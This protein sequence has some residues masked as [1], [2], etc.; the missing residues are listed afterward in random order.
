MNRSSA[1][2]VAAVFSLS[3]C[4]PVKTSPTQPAHGQFTPSA[5]TETMRKVADWQIGSWSTNGFAKPKYNWTYCAAYT[6]IFQAGLATGDGKYH[7]FLRKVGADLQ[8]RTGKRRYFADDYC[9]GQVFSQ[10]YAQ[11]RQPEMIAPWRT[12]A[13]EIVGK[14]NNESL[15]LATHDIIEREWA[16]CDALFMGPT[17]LAYL[18]T[19]T[20]DRKY[21][22][23]ALKLWWKTSDF[24]YS[25]EERLYF[26]DESYFDK[27][28]K[29]GKKVFWSRGNGWVMA[30]MV[31]V[32][33]NMPPDHPDRARLL[34]QYRAMAARIAGLQTA[35]GTWH[36]SL[37]DPGSFPT[38]ETSGTA[39]YTYAILWGLNSGM[40][41]RAT[42]WPVV[43]RA[44]PALA[45]AVQPDGKLGYVQPVGAAPD[46]VDANS[47]ETYGPG[48]FLLAG[49]ELLEYIKR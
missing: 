14:P 20:G 13:D 2:L 7:D 47:T 34:A 9:V 35:D 23:T 6:G 48:A 31:R 17:S 46:K 21:L 3:A 28:E 10:L 29:N 12:L 19:V 33:S 44:W 45:S 22:D 1:I 25:P 42:Y 11:D 8:W 37:L 43:E 38:R 16:W 41:D 4:G 49:S 24:L 18:S 5:I 32:L 27:R 39:F 36:A 40:L 26:R 15:S 30:G